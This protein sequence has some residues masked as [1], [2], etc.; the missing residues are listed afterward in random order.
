MQ[1]DLIRSARKTIAIQIKP[2]GT[3]VVRAPLYMTESRINAFISEKSFWVEKNVNKM[4]SAVLPKYTESETENFIVRAKE[5]LPH[6][7]EHFSEII[8]VTFK[9][10]NVKKARTLWGSCTVKGVI[11]LNCLLVN[12]PKEI[13]DYVVIHE[14]C[15]LRHM[16]H[17]RAFWEE[18]KKY[19]PDYK[20]RRK[21]LKE[22][23]GK[24]LQRI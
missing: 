13:T 10:I 23:G 9:K 20:Y 19:C 18:V 7:A 4:R 16:N 1:Y 8:G 11:N 5:L 3:I 14:L 2:D 17:S 21:W 22:N 12:L 24:F 15:H 6:I